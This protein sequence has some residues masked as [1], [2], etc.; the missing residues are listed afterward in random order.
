MAELGLLAIVRLDLSNIKELDS[1]ELAKRTGD[2]D[3]PF[4]LWCLSVRMGRI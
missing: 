1:I 3:L 4:P 2:L